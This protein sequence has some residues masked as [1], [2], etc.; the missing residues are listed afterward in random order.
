MS[1]YMRFGNLNRYSGGDTHLTRNI[2]EDVHDRDF[3]CAVLLQHILAVGALNL[4]PE[5]SHA[6]DVIWPH[7]S[8]PSN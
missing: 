4:D 3:S 5:P 6:N 1:T 2:Q 7:A 8:T